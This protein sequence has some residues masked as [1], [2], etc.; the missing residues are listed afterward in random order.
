MNHSVVLGERTQANCLAALLAHW[1]LAAAL[2][3][4]MQGSHCAVLQG[5]VQANHC[6]ALGRRR[7]DQSGPPALAVLHIAADVPNL[8]LATGSGGAVAAAL[9]GQLLEPLN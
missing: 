3:T 9:E 4:C 8:V 7:W 6:T 2:E 1:V 5:C